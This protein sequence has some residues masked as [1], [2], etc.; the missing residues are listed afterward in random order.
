MKRLLITNK[1]EHDE[2]IET[3][4][5]QTW[6]P[7]DGQSRRAEAC[8]TLVRHNDLNEIGLGGTDT[9]RSR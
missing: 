8:L 3:N 1:K 2:K 6:V 7:E 9:D 4:Q 5:S